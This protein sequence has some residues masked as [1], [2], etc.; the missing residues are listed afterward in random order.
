MVYIAEGND[1]L[2]MKMCFHNDDETK[3]SNDFD[4]L[5]QVKMSSLQSVFVYE[6]LMDVLV[7]EEK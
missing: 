5:V 7:S 2:K 1:A 3:K 4:M 6:F